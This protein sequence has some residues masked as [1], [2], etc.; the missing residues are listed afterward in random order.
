MIG[1]Q[2]PAINVHKVSKSFGPNK[3]LSNISVALG[4][5]ELFG[6][7]G[8]NGAGKTT[9]FRV[10][11]GLLNPNKGY[12]RVL[13]YDVATDRIAVQQ[14]IGYIPGDVRLYGNISGQDNLE[15]FGALHSL[16]PVRRRE[17]IERF[18]LTGADLQRK[19]RSYSSGMR[20]KVAIIATF[21]H[22][23]PVYILDEPTEGLDPLMQAEFAQLLDE[24]LG[25]GKS[26]LISSHTLSE[27]ERICKRVA[28][29]KK[30]DIV[31]SGSLDTLRKSALR[32]LDVVFTKAVKPNWSKFR[33][34]ETVSGT[35]RHH[36]VTFQGSPKRLL[37]VLAE[38]P[39]EDVNLASA[40]LEQAFKSFYE[41]ES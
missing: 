40:S 39:V 14:Q 13:G 18:R 12:V 4:E 25:R 24:E 5:G 29:I 7:L 41:E 15:F 11:N 6:V 1:N 26:I 16:P 28:F 8:P 20:Q 32:Q 3:V 23:P 33:E 17:M 9:L 10:I 27:V 2:I 36:I 22:D 19:V 35:P 31:F 21:Q 30:G 34:V 37:S 38:L